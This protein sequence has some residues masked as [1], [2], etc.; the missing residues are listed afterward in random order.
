MG[1]AAALAA[2]PTVPIAGIQGEKWNISFPAST[3]KQLRRASARLIQKGRRF[4]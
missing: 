4:C 2:C 1:F 3:Q